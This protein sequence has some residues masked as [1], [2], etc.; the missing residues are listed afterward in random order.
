ML[1]IIGCCLTVMY[2]ITIFPVE[3]ILISCIIFPVEN[4][5]FPVENVKFPVEYSSFM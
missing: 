1:F 3:L 5:K 2:N 4:V